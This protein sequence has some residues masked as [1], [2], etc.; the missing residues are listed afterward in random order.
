MENRFDPALTV[1]FIRDASIFDQ[2]SNA[3]KKKILHCLFDRHYFT[4]QCISK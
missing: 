1:K 4:M 3:K 2:P